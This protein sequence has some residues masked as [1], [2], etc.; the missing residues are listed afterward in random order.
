MKGGAAPEE[1]LPCATVLCRNPPSRESA[2]GALPPH[3][4]D[5]EAEAQG[6]WAGPGLTQT[7]CLSAILL[8]TEI[9]SEMRTAVTPRQTQRVLWSC[10]DIWF[11]NWGPHTLGPRG[12]GEGACQGLFTSPTLLFPIQ[13]A[14]VRVWDSAA[15]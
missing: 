8:P 1:R 12:G 6:G 14:Q 2:A 15:G 3:L 5:E 9:V 13:A 11:L 10:D 4:T 7:H